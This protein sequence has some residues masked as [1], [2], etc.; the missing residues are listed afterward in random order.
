MKYADMLD[1]IQDFIKQGLDPNSVTIRIDPIVPG[2]TKIK[3]V[4][5]VIKR[6]TEMGIKNIRFSVM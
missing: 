4:E 6:A 3:D 5:N 2:V 1:R